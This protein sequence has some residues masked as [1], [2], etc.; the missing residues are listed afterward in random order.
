MNSGD[1][2]YDSNSMRCPFK[3]RRLN[4]IY[5]RRGEY[6]FTHS[7]EGTGDKRL[8]VLE[9]ETCLKTQC[10]FLLVGIGRRQVE[11]ETKG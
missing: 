2:S 3:T 8:T 6:S 4:L 10:C 1:T 7:G 5:E 9:A 11:M